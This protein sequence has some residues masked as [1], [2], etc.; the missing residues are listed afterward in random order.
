M[1]QLQLYIEGQEVEMFKDESFTLTQSIQDIRDIS[2][3][4][5]DFSRTFN[6]PASKINNKL[7][8]HFYDFNIIGFDARKKKD[9]TL[10]MNYKPFKEGKIKLE[11]VQLKNNEPET[12]K[13]TFYGNAVNL[14][15]ILGEDKLSGL[16]N[17]QYFNFE[18]N[19]TNIQTYLTDGKDVEF[20]GETIADSIV[21]PL[22]T[23]SDRLIYDLTSN[24]TDT[25]KNINSTASAVDKGVPVSQL[26]P[27]LRLYAIIRAIEVQ[28]PELQFSREFFSTSNVPFY[29]LYMW[30]HNK[31]GKLFLDQE[32]QYPVSG[33]TVIEA[34]GNNI[35][36]W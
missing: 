18:Y 21:F 26:K 25:I 32:A 9:A 12:Y 36:G 33:L 29:S 23:V 15:D 3:V 34:D 13:L 35:S 22:I 20:F 28:Y 19:D 14:K 11:G 27:A 17:L 1:V 4:F 2:K 7:F 10:L 5:T 8:K 30:L 16:V 24:N 31:E 6:V